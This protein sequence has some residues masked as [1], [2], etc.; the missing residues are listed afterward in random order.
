MSENNLINVTDYSSWTGLEVFGL[1]EAAYLI[2]G[3]EPRVNK[4]EHP[5]QVESIA[6]ALFGV[7]CDRHEDLPRKI[8]FCDILIDDIEAYFQLRGGKSKL[9]DRLRKQNSTANLN[10]VSELKEEL[11]KQRIS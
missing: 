11:K 3:Y 4:K 8:E 7:W 10:E 9:L 5:D 6:Q 1:Y 2:A